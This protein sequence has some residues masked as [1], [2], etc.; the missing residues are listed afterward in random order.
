MEQLGPDS[1]FWDVRQCVVDRNSQNQWV[2]V[3]IINTVNE[4]L[5][6]GQAVTKPTVLREGDTIAVG[7]S[8]KGIIKMPVVVRGR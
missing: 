6:D 3:P 8:A 2:L 5:L 7:R 1:H 4:T